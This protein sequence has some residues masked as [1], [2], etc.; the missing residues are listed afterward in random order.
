MKM[1]TMYLGG[2]ALA[3]ALG[4]GALAQ[5][6]LY[7]LVP[8]PG[9]G[10]DLGHSVSGGGDLDGDGYPDIVTGAPATSV[11]GHC[12]GLVVVFSGSDGG[13]IFFFPGDTS[14]D[15]FGWSVSDVGDVDGDGFADVVA[16]APC[17]YPDIS[18]GYARLF[19]GS[20]G[21]SLHTWYASSLDDWFGTSV[22]GAGDMN[23][24]GSPDV[25]VGASEEDGSGLSDS[26]RARVFSLQA[27]LLY[28]FAGHAA[29][30]EFGYS[31]SDAGDV[32]NDG[33]PDIVVGARYDH[34]AGPAAGSA[35]VFSGKDGVSLY[36]FLGPAYAH[37]GYCVSDA[38]DVNADGYA[39]VIVGG[40]QGSTLSY[41]NV[42]SGMDGV[43]IHTFG[44][45]GASHDEGRVVSGAGDVDQDGLADLLLQTVFPWGVVARSGNDG[46]E[47]FRLDGETASDLFGVSLSDAGDINGDGIPEIIAGS[48]SGYG[49]VISTDCGTIQVMGQGCPGSAPAA[50]ALQIT[51]CAVPGAPVLVGLDAVSFLPVPAL[52]LAGTGTTSLPMGGGCSLLVLPPLVPVWVMTGMFGVLALETRIPITAPLGAFAVQ[53]FI[54]DAAAPTGF[55]NSNAVVISV[56]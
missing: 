52:L 32:N 13:P 40:E 55:R 2:P 11:S 56:E 18:L 5:G 53:A 48:A 29:G 27:G 25:L 24:D 28:T 49:R 36:R 38:G 51:G 34:S 45:S 44:L 8:V 30:D 9:L 1:V 43:I 17:H 15:S 16:G 4:Q 3:L 23:G 31:V 14:D 54:P 42:Y 22:S 50:P 7:R 20:S 21:V 39:D 46:T 19:S 12:S 6:D 35:E 37:L 33:F 26:G 41:A 47:L 10:G